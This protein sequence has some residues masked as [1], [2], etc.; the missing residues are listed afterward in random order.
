MSGEFSSY[1]YR[2]PASPERLEAQLR[3]ELAEFVPVENKTEAIAKQI[4]KLRKQIEINTKSL[5]RSRACTCH[6]GCHEMD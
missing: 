6:C 4:E 2:N 5:K 3:K 1:F